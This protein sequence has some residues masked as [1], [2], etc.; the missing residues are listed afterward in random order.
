MKLNG[1]KINK[2]N[3]LI[4]FMSVIIISIL[5][6]LILISLVIGSSFDGG[7]IFYLKWFLTER[8]FIFLLFIL[9]FSIPSFF[10]IKRL[11]SKEPKKVFKIELPRFSIVY[12]LVFMGFMFFGLAAAGPM[13]ASKLFYLLFILAP[14]PFV[15]IWISLLTI[16]LYFYYKK[17]NFFR[18]K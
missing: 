15:V 2:K 11:L 14:I 16:S 10:I 18:K 5:I 12:S 9:I 6:F 4:P 1:V 3:F 13:G 7:K 8:F 17:N